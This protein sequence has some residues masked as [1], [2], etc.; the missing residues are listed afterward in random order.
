MAEL[1]EQILKAAAPSGEEQNKYLLGAG[2]L[3]YL[4]QKRQAD[5]LRL[6][7]KYGSKVQTVGK[8]IDFA[9]RLL[10]AHSVHPG[11][12]NSTR[13]VVANKNP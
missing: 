13:E 6:W 11:T 8:S 9:L 12:G 5:G 4:A 3:S 2:M 10:I 1:A 7:S